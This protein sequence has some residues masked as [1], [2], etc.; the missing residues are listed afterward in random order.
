MR[1]SAAR[2]RLVVAL[3]GLALGAGGC[4]ATSSDVQDSETGGT[5]PMVRD[6][7]AT[8]DL[9]EWP[10]R[11][12]LGLEPG[13]RGQAYERSFGSDGI[14]TRVIMPGGAEVELLA[15][16]IAHNSLSATS[17]TLEAANS[18]P[19]ARTVVNVRFGS[20]EDAARR[21]AEQAPALGLDP[22]RIAELTGEVDG[23]QYPATGV[24]RGG[25]FGDWL[26]VEVELRGGAGDLTGNYLFSYGEPPRVDG[27]ED[28]RRYDGP[29]DPPT[30]RPRR[31]D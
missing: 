16:G 1:A 12:E 31:G 22:R 11:E 7:R 17:A 10:T 18:A 23:A 25:S 6:D 28:G 2:R 21:L 26:S 14:V 30:L 13:S 15:F 9:R 3:L 19:P 8:L 27:F 4:A 29:A 5:P 20:Y 24:L